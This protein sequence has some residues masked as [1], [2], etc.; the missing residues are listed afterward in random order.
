M[1]IISTPW[2]AAAAVDVSRTSVES[3]WKEGIVAIY[4]ND[5]MWLSVVCKLCCLGK[6]DFERD[7]GALISA[8]NTSDV[9]VAFLS[10]CF[11]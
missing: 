4:V 10:N 7:C 9:V 3:R 6:N 8:D 11:R 5:V 2:A 1:Q